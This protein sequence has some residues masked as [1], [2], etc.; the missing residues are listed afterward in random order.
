M[1]TTTSYEILSQRQGKW[2]IDGITSD[3][4]E[5]INRANETLGTGHYEAVKVLAEKVDEETGETT[6]FTV[7]SKKDRRSAKTGA[8]GGTDKRKKSERRNVPD[9]RTK[10]R[11]KKKKKSGSFVNFLV[12]TCLIIWAIGATV[13]FL[14][15]SLSP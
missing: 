10:G 2:E 9:R 7:L 5:A 13:A 15:C 11:R 3:K 12:K 6:T 8:F 4:N 14:I 1:A